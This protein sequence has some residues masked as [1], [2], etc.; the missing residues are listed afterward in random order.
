MVGNGIMEARRAVASRNRLPGGPFP[1][2]ASMPEGAP[3]PVAHG[4]GLQILH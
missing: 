1:L 4:T 3:S 2:P